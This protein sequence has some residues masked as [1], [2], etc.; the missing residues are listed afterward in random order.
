MRAATQ[1]KQQYEDVKHD[2]A[3]IEGVWDCVDRNV[4]NQTT[5][6]RYG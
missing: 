4:S 3:Y 2:L 1:A 5:R 6:K